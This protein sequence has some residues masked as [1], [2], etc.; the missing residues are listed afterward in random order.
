MYFHIPS[1]EPR[2]KLTINTMEM[3]QKFKHSRLAIAN[4]GT[5]HIQEIYGI[6]QLTIL[7][8]LSFILRR[9]CTQLQF[10]FTC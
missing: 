10:L 5:E 2:T 7:H 1:P 4:E 3:C 8:V 9:K 6:F